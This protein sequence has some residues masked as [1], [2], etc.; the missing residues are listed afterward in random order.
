LTWRPAERLTVT[1][2]ARYQSDG[3]RRIG[4]LRM[5]PE[6]PLDYDKRTHAFLPKVSTAY[7]VGDHVRVGLLVQRAYNPGGVTLDPA[8]RAQLEFKP[9]YLWDYE[10]F[11]RA[12]L[13][14]GR[15]RIVGNL[16]YNAMRDAQ[17][18]HDFDFN[19]PGGQ[20]GL[21]QILSE[22]R[23]RSYGAELEL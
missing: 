4:V 12:S 22:P 5:T 20:V 8:H 3:K 14:G 1:A 6:L 21:L 13:F 18:E 16:F 15:V 2:G 17:R 10:A 19:S 9:E 11:T 7:D 23:A